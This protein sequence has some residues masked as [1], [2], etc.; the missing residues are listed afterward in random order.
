[1][2]YRVG[3]LPWSEMTD[4]QHSP[5]TRF[6]ERVSVAAYKNIVIS[7]S[8]LANP[9]MMTGSSADSKSVF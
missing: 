2:P 6:S 3:W 7:M 4:C 8:Y 1:M 5:N 9:P